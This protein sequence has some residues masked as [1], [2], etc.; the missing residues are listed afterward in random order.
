MTDTKNMSKKRLGL[1]LFANIITHAISILVSFI[2]TPFLINSLGKELYGFYGMANNVVNYINVVAI[3]LNSMASKYITVE[4]VK[5]NNKRALEYYS[6]VFFSNVLFCVL[7]S[8]FLTVFVFNL[9]NVFVISDKYV[10]DVRILFALIFIAMIIRLIT[11]VTGCAT[12]STNRTDLRAYTDLAKSV[13]KVLLFISIF[14]IFKPSIIHVGLVMLF[15]E[16]FN[17]LLHIILAKRLTPFLKIKKSY[18]RIKLIISTLKVGVWN[19]VNQVGDLLLSSSD[20]FVGNIMLG[21]VASGTVN[22]IKTIPALLSGVITAINVVFMPRIAVRYGQNNSEKLIEEVKMSQRIMGIFTTSIVMVVIF[23]GKEFFEL[24]VPNDDSNL[25]MLLSAVDVSRMMII[26]VTWPVANLNIVMDKIRTPSLFVVLSGVTNVI[27]MVVLIRYTSI[28]ILA[29]PLTTLIISILYY[30]LFIP[31]YSAKQMK[32][33]WKTFMFPVL[34]MIL[35]GICISLL[36]FSLKSFVSITSW[37]NFFI[38]GGLFGIIAIIVS[39]LI[40]V[41]PKKIIAF[42]L[43]IKKI[44]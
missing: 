10:F 42:L 4:L 16:V 27:S 13:L 20:L 22:I 33:S 17:S 43:S 40:F 25:L 39:L 44:Q 31:I 30:G 8:P 3:A 34:E 5:G 35:S 28:G 14:I 32:L 9:Q 29:I 19:S 12:Y 1:N 26:G 23:F 2:L 6:S 7:L 24:W 37:I 11:S 15:L 41:K 36:F 38:F 21:E 18:Y